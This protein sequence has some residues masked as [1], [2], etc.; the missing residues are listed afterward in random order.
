M[1]IVNGVSNFSFHKKEFT[2]LR[3]KFIRLS[4]GNVEKNVDEITKLLM[5]LDQDVGKSIIA[6]DTKSNHY[7]E[8]LL[9]GLLGNPL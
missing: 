4:Y 8:K 5:D 1:I 3:D 7:L 2:D 6:R 9:V